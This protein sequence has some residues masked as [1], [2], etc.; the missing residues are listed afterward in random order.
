VAGVLDALPATRGRGRDG[1]GLRPRDSG[2]RDEVRPAAECRDDV[3]A[4]PVLHAKLAGMADPLGR[5]V[6]IGRLPLHRNLAPEVI[7]PAV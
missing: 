4:I 1:S 2:V 3:Q 7:N 6:V 5:E